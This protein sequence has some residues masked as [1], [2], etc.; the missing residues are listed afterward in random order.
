MRIDEPMTV[1]T[2]MMLAACLF[3][4][5]YRLWC[6]KGNQASRNK[7]VWSAWLCLFV[8]AGLGAF[9]GGMDHGFAYAYPAWL[10][11]VS[12]RATLVLIGV[13]ALSLT[14]L[15]RQFYVGRF[16]AWSAWMGVPLFVCYVMAVLFWSQKFIL[17]IVY[18]VPLV[19]ITL[20]CALWAWW[21][22]RHRRD[23][24][25]VIGLVVSLVAAGIQVS[26]YRLF[27]HFN[28]NDLYHV[29]QMGAFF[30]LYL[31]A[32]ESLKRTK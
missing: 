11:M 18:Y 32:C 15:W 6:S 20:V 2:D 29:I 21:S 27:P 1:W 14:Q 10:K 4:W 7:V 22:F 5:A 30:L 13:S 17:A 12:W 28:H 24:Y 3:I 26:G 31:S 9:V 8:S 19:L 16:Q 23:L 25:L